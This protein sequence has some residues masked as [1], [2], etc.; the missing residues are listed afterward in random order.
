[1][2]LSACLLGGLLPLHHMLQLL[3]STHRMQRQ[4]IIAT[5]QLISGLSQLPLQLTH[6]LLRGH[7]L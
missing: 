5:L 7:T 4:R 6:R 1:M 2:P 3:R